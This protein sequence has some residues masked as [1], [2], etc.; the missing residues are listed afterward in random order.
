VLTVASQTFLGSRGGI[1][2][3]CELTARVALESGYP[4]CLLSVQDE[5][6]AYQD[7]E[8]WRGCNGSRAKFVV[9]C[10][11]AALRGDRILY[12]QLGTGRAH[13]WPAKLTRP[14]GVWIHGIEV[15]DQLRA[16]RLRVAH[17]L[18]FILANTNFTRERAIGYDKVFQSARVCWL[19]TYEDDAPVEAAD[20]DGPPI[21]LILGRLDDAAY[22]GH[23]ELIEAWPAVVNAVPEARLVIVGTGPS[24]DRHR[25]LAAASKAAAYIDVV[26]FLADSSLP[27]LW[28]RTVVFAMPSRGEGF[29]L[30]YIEAMRWGVPVVASVHDAGSEV[31]IHNETGLNVDLNRRTDLTD[32][33]IELLRNRDL[34][35]RMGAAGQRRW[36]KYFRYSAF[37]D[38]FSEELRRFVEL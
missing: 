20:L 5:G 1:A 27:K 32:S 37:R 16:D 12:D 33:L 24:L 2:R 6:G 4:L 15:W 38:R 10:G 36:Y 3:V 14:S 19:A 17:R 30:A 31:N 7:A 26:G 18:A 13:I 22:K 21:V 25:S 8:F 34:A 35:H 23:K 9:E 29:G 11:R 28:R